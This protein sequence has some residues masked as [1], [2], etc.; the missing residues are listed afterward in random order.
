MD[1]WLLQE[2]QVAEPS[3]SVFWVEMDFVLWEKQCIWL[4]YFCE[5]FQEYVEAH[6]EQL[7]S[8]TDNLRLEV[9]GSGAKR[10]KKE[11][12]SMTLV[13]VLM[14]SKSMENSSLK[15]IGH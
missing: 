10:R 5:I 1:V 9:W 6:N 3:V 4:Q 11:A 12:S 15:C 2:K 13:P 8:R 7:Q 14:Y